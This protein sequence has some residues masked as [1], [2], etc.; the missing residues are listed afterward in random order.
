[1]PELVW[2]DKVADIYLGPALTAR[3]TVLEPAYTW[4]LACY[5]AQRSQTA[6]DPALAARYGAAALTQAAHLT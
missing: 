3:L 4:R 5:C 2:N 6:P 1:M